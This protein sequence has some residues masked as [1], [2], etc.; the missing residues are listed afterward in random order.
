MS[1]PRKISVTTKLASVQKMLQGE[2]AQ[3]NARFRLFCCVMWKVP[4][5]FL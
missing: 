4:L 1:K 5:C 3:N 2:T